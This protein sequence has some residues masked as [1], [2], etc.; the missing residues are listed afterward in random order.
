[1]YYRCND[2]GH[3]FS[4][5]KAIEEPRGEYWGVPCS[6]TLYVCPNCGG[7]DIDEIDR[8]YDGDEDD[9][10][11]LEEDEYYDY[12]IQSIND[13]DTRADDAYDEYVASTM[14]D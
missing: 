4:R 7:D 9:D 13:G 1:M 10:D 11:E 6:E 5:L 12:L 3:E 14:P 8:D 2:C